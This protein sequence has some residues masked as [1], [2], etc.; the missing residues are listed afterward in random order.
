MEKS[1]VWTQPGRE[2]LELTLQIE[3]G[4]INDVKMNSIGCLEFLQ[5]SQ[6]MKQKL[7]GPIA[8]LL[9]PS[10]TDHSSMIWREIVSKIQDEW[11]LPVAHEE[12]CHCRKVTTNAVDRAIVFGAHSL[13]EVRKRTSANTGCGTCKND[14]EQLISYR[15][16]IS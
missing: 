4:V 1:I 11:N 2:H 5:L 14:V 6:K 7:K 13:D 8:Q 16:R 9:P 12:L 15:K 3:E 10:G